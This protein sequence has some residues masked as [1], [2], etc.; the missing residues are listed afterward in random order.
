MPGTRNPADTRA[1]LISAAERLMA[2]RGVDAVSLREVNR[3][4]G[5]LAAKLAD[6][7]GRREILQIYADLVNRPKPSLPISMDDPTNS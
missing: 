4:S 3:S 5:S 7:D 6:P 1:S 2:E